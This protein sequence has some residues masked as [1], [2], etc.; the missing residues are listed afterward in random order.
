MAQ[1]KNFKSEDV[2]QNRIKIMKYVRIFSKLK[3]SL[4]S[5]KFSL[6]SLKFS[7]KVLKFHGTLMESTMASG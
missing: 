5:L 3:L 7:L 6:K 4:K 2:E 1:E